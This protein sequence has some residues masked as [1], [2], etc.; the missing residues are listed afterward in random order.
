MTFDV[1]RAAERFLIRESRMLDERRYQE[2]LALLT[3]DFHYSL[4]LPL[5]R[6]DP[7][8]PRY[9]DRGVFFEA[10]KV[11][12]ELK[13]GRIG[14]RTAWSDRPHNV[15]RRFVSNVEVERVDER[16]LLATSNV[17]VTVV[18]AGEPATLTSAGR[19]DLL[20]T[21]ADGAFMLA[22]RTVYLDVEVPSDVQLSFV[23]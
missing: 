12:L 7:H 22:R 23:F 21:S 2:W 16:H 13:L 9:H 8:L 5:V 18:P 1:D 10:T 11:G 4:P 14:E 20:R 3:D 17:L 6:E 15:T 19:K